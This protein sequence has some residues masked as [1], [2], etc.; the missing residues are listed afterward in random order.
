MTFEEAKDTV[1]QLSKKPSNDA[2][3][4]LYGLYKQATTG[5]NNTEKP[6]GF[7][8]KALAK[9]A[10]WSNEQGKS[11]DEAKVEYVALVEKLKIEL[12]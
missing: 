12:G 3:L 2:L 8:F 9:Y 5:D 4:L 1:H 11:S 10:S 6:T 7:D